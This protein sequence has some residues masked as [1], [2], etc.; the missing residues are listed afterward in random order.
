MPPGRRI[1]L[2]LV[3]DISI[4]A[5]GVRAWCAGADSPIEIVAAGPDVGIACSDVRRAC[6]VVLFDLYLAGPAPALAGLRRLVDNECRVVVL[7]TRDGA[8]APLTCMDMGALGC[9]LLVRTFLRCLAPTHLSETE[10]GERAAIAALL[11]EGL[12]RLARWPIPAT[13]M[14]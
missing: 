11:A 9:P 14:L 2:T 10:A 12:Y 1:A 6:D 8:N 13:A 5:A 3:T 4:I 7:A